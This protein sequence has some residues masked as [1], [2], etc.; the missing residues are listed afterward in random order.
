MCRNGSNIR[1]CCENGAHCAK[2]CLLLNNE[3]LIAHQ[4][5]NERS[6]FK[7]VQSLL[8]DGNNEFNWMKKKESKK[9]ILLRD[10]LDL[11]LLKVNCNFDCLLL[12]YNKKGNCFYFVSFWAFISWLWWSI[13]DICEHLQNEIERMRIVIDCSWFSQNVLP[14]FKDFDLD[15]VSKDLETFLLP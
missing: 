2:T 14:P 13:H 5:Q 9:L 11:T 1:S 12:K 3:I 7:F 4:W 6:E 15:V 8:Y 10:C